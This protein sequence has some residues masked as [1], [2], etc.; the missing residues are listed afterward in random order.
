[1]IV[2]PPSHF[3][4][5]DESSPKAIS[6]SSLD[7]SGAVIVI[8]FLSDITN[9]QSSNDNDPNPFKYLMTFVD[10]ILDF[11]KSS[12]LKKYFLL[13]PSPTVTKGVFNIFSCP[14]TIT[15]GNH[16]HHYRNTHTVET[17]EKKV[18]IKVK[19]IKI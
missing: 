19:M 7:F 9:S 13:F 15:K 8:N 14:F 17:G 5:I 16:L 2:M 12:I 6:R 4:L 11:L 10:I 18:K 3:F 1:M